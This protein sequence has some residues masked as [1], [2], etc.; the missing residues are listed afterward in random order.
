MHWAAVRA[1]NRLNR[2]Q[3]SSGLV[4]NEIEGSV[5]GTGALSVFANSAVGVRQK[6]A[7][8]G[9][10]G[11]LPRWLWGPPRRVFDVGPATAGLRREA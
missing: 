7:G 1:A 6:P 5:S 4:N 11:T 3:E 9:L 2:P 8:D 10:R